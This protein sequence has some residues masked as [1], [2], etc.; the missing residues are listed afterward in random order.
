MIHVEEPPNV[1]KHPILYVLRGLRGRRV[2]EDLPLGHFA[3]KK[4]P[5]DSYTSYEHVMK[6][7][8]NVTFFWQMDITFSSTE[9]QE[10]IT[11]FQSVNISN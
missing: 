9:V 4:D 2:A 5:G 7:Q 3:Q 1:A 10:S 6:C 8:N 11:Y